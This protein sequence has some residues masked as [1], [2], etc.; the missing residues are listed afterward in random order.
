MTEN[1]SQLNAPILIN[2]GATLKPKLEQVN[3]MASRS[4][5][6]YFSV[7]LFPSDKVYS[8]L[9]VGKTPSLKSKLE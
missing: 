8:E 6:M 4:V 2:D 9:W 7:G 1:L 5:N 3:E